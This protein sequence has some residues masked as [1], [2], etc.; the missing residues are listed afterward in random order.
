MANE[1]HVYHED[2]RCIVWFILNNHFH[3]FIPSQ[4]SV[5]SAKIP[6][7]QKLNFEK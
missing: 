3:S 1:F 7:F 6:D 5:N 2:I 4:S